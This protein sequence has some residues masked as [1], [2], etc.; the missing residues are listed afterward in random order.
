[1]KKTKFSV[2]L[3]CY[4]VMVSL[5][6]LIVSASMMSVRMIG[7]LENDMQLTS[8]QTMDT[9]MTSFQRYTKTLSLPI[10]LMCRS[11]DFKKIDENYEDR[12]AAIEDSLLSALKVIPNSERTYYSTISGRYI[13]AKMNVSE[14][15]KKTGEYVE[16][17][18][19]DNTAKDWFA[20]SQG[21]GG[22]YT[23]FANFTDPYVNDDGVNVFTV[24]QD[25]KSGDEHVGVVAMDINVQVLEEYINSI[26]LMNTG[27]TFLVNGAGNIIVNNEKMM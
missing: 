9:A 3:V 16:E 19:V 6:A 13:Q 12:L 5:V 22:R 14:D 23:V 15:G 27:F 20:D 1:M 10:D 2:K 24:S 8:R 17:T 4:I 7:I 25:L 26:G 21:L 18:G 11:N